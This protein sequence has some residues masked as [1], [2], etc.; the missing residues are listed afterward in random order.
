MIRMKTDSGWLLIPHQDHARLAGEF[1]QCWGN[2]RFCMPEPHE[3]VGVAVSRHDDA[4]SARDRHPT[5]APDGTPS[6]FSRELV[7]TYSAFENIDLEAYLR[8][9]GEATEAVAEDNPAAAVLVSMHTVNLLTE[10]ADLSALSPS[11]REVHA[12]FIAAQRARQEELKQSVPGKERP[13]E[14]DWQAAFR[15]LQGCDSLSLVACVR[16]ASPIPL[17]H[18][19][20]TQDGG[21]SEIICYPQEAD[22]YRLDP[23]PLNRERPVFTVAAKEIHGN[24]FASDT[25]LQAAYDAGTPRE[26]K[27]TIHP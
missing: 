7:G 14:A 5:I 11:Q 19:Q 1:A 12:D 8:V 16:Y 13:S 9:R 15:F 2:E 20:A 18:A 26:I 10:Q 25:E 6:A 21:H 3:A 4:W 27:I 17:R 24:R 23:F 22:H